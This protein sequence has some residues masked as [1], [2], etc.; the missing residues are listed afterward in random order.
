MLL[1]QL[2]MVVGLIV[3]CIVRLLVPD[4]LRCLALC[5]FPAWLPVCRLCVRLAGSQQASWPA[6]QPARQYGVV[7]TFC[8]LVL[9][10]IHSICVNRILSQHVLCVCEKD[11]DDDEVVFCFNYRGGTMDGRQMDNDDTISRE[12]QQQPCAS[13]QWQHQPHQQQQLQSPSIH[14]HVRLS[15]GFLNCGGNNAAARTKWY[16]L[17]GIAMYTFSFFR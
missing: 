12:Q 11:N 4:C 17:D 3:R 9:V 13:E 6:S 5:C 8:K 7:L 2:V 1:L 15:V 14:P 16:T 10:C